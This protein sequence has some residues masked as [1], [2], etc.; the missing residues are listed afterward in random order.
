MYKLKDDLLCWAKDVEKTTLEQAINVLNHP[1]R[2]GNVCL[3]PDTHAG[4]GMPIGCV[5]ALDNA[6]SPNMVGVDIGCGMLTVKTKLTDISR[7]DL[8]K[9]QRKIFDIVPVGFNHRKSKSN[10][11]I[12]DKLD[13][14]KTT[15]CKREK[16]SARNQ[17]GT[18]GGGNHFIEIQKG[19]DGHIYFT[20]H[21]GS[22]NLGLKVATHYDTLANKIAEDD[23]KGYLVS[24]KLSVLPMNSSVAKQYMLEHD[25][26]L[27]FA[28]RN[29]E[30]MAQDIQAIIES[31]TGTNDIA[32][33]KVA[34]HHNYVTKE[35]VNGKQVYVHRKGA[36]YAGKGVRGI[37][38][39]SQ[40]TNSYLVEGLGNSASLNSS[41]HGA[42][43]VLSR[44]QAKKVLNLQH[45]KEI[46]DKQG[47]VHNI[48]SANDLD[49]APSSY[50]D[51]EIVMDEQK[52]LTKIVV[53]LKPLMVVKG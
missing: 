45:E 35:K 50:K 33:D 44:T 38:P 37:I 53:E 30:I 49:E 1:N 3:M 11:D 2:F 36:V 10:D 6:V 28:L 52:D 32:V 41:S 19:D 46:L 18:L 17:I 16:S 13:W 34:I 47:V 42:G 39:G 14:E 23:K 27:A 15:V 5:V 43:R 40:G 20:I 24:Q 22:R 7:D 51:I 8:I 4:M 29:R 12:F 9:I 26:C 25:I 48:K 21:S 31:V